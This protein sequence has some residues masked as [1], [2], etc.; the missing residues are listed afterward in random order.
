MQ[1]LHLVLC[2]CNSNLGI[3]VFNSQTSFDKNTNNFF[4]FFIWLNLLPIILFVF[5]GVAYRMR[6][7]MW[8]M[9]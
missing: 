1:N 8:L 2:I 5:F 6:V 9:D 7:A 4:L 3:W